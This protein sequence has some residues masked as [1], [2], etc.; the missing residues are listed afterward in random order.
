MLRVRGGGAAGGRRL[1][2]RPPAGTA[3]T[4]ATL[5]DHTRSQNACA[6]APHST[7]RPTSAPPTSTKLSNEQQQTMT[8]DNH[9]AA[10]SGEQTSC[11]QR[12]AVHRTAPTLV[13]CGGVS[14]PHHMS[15]SRFD[16]ADG[17]WDDLCW[18]SAW[19]RMWTSATKQNCFPTRILALH[20]CRARVVGGIG[21]H[22]GRRSIQEGCVLGGVTTLRSLTLP[23][24]RRSPSLRR[25][26]P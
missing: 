5:R 1:P 15:S 6:R 12:L 18:L 8:I 26:F 2:P 7:K 16:C 21:K 10:E 9:V 25:R 11:P 17:A 19:L 20:R 24:L 4:P 22:A 3:R 14:A 23:P 13:P